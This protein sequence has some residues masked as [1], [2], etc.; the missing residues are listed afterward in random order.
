MTGERQPPGCIQANEVVWLLELK[1]RTR[2]IYDIRNCRWYKQFI[3]KNQLKRE[4][5]YF[6]L[7]CD[8]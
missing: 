5:V 2:R 4:K 7:F 1:R 8:S 3:S 6:L